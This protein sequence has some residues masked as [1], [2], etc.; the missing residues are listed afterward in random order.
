MAQTTT[1]TWPEFLTRVA[2]NRNGTGRVPRPEMV[3]LYEALTISK[4]TGT[5]LN[6]DTG[7]DLHTDSWEEARLR[8]KAFGARLT[9]KPF[10]EETRIARSDDSMHVALEEWLFVNKWAVGHGQNGWLVYSEVGHYGGRD[11]E[12]YYGDELQDAAWAMLE[13]TKLEVRDGN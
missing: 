9:W 6:T 4:A 13:A 5:Y 8:V 3:E 2:A 11:N 10:P 7:E 1:L 12:R